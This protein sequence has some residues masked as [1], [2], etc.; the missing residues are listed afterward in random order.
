LKD[1]LGFDGFVVSDWKGID[2]VHGDF[3]LAIKAAINIG[4]DMAM[5]P[6]NYIEFI[7]LLTQLVNEGQVPI[8]RIDDAVARILAGKFRLG[9]FENPYASQ[10]LV[11]TVGCNSHRQKARQAVRESLVVLKNDGLLPLSK[12]SGKVLVAGYK[13]NNVGA[14]CGGWTISWQGGLGNITEGTTIYEGIA[15]TIGSENVVD[16]NNPNQLPEA[17]YAVVVV[18]ESPY[19]E[20]SGDIYWTNGSVFILSVEDKAM[21][22]AVKNTNIPMIIVLLSGRPLDIRDELA[23]ANAFVADWLQGSEGGSGIADILF[24][25]YLPVGKLSQTWP[26]SSYYL[27]EYSCKNQG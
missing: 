5:Q 26:K 13:G 27:F 25:D 23:D 2:Q 21:V 16:S 18:R 7:N 8:E 22:R 3:K 14:M 4:I 1:E 10:S 24:G 9:L 19:A 6:D 12:N 20:G 11:D 17:D 15:E